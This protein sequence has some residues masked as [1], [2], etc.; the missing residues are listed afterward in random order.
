MRR[1]TVAIA[2]VSLAV[3]GCSDDSSTSDGPD[4]VAAQKAP[5]LDGT[6]DVSS[7]ASTATSDDATEQPSPRLVS[8]LPEISGP[9]VLWFW[10]PG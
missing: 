9:T 4:S 10:A 8:S 3:V 2:L 1:A 5:M 7:P 6:S